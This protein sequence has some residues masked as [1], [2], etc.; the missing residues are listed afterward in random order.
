MANWRTHRRDEDAAR[1]SVFNEPDIFPGRGDE[2][3]EQDW[4]CSACGYNLRGLPVGRAC[5]ECGHV[6]L[7]RPPPPGQLSYVAWYRQRQAAC[8]AWRS[9]FVIALLTGL[10][11]VW[12]LVSGLPGLVPTA[13][14]IVLMG[15]AAVELLKLVGLALLVESRPYLIK[16]RAQLIVAGLLSAAAL[17]VGESAVTTWARGN[18]GMWLLVW[19]WMACPALQMICTLVAVQG[20]VSA[21]LA[22]D[23]DGRSPR[24]DRAFT[25]MVLAIG[26]HVA[27]NLI[28]VL[29]GQ[30]QYRF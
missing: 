26:I 13:V 7:Y 10:S 11:F 19:R 3:I 25:P 2:V 18:P 24:F 21:W 27:F 14:T 17:G 23:R 20:L 8:P 30:P 4:Q 5:P 9:W 12:G 29:W 22:A 6:E 16:S 1:H 15:P 28:V